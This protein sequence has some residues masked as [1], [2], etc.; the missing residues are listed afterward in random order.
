MIMGRLKKRIGLA[1]DPK[2]VVR[3]D[4]WLG[5]QPIPISKT[6][7]YETALREFLERREKGDK[8]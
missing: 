1:L 7:A 4:K 6:A 2:L 5:S 8:R 3:L